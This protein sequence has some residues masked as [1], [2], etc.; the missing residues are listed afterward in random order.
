[1]VDVLHHNWEVKGSYLSFVMSEDERKAWREPLRTSLFSGVPPFINYV[2]SSGLHFGGHSL[3]C[4]PQ[5]WDEDEVRPDQPRCGSSVGRASFKRSG[6]GAT[7]LTDVTWVQIPAPWQ[8]EVGKLLA[9]LSGER[10]R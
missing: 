10:L 5:Y 1:M 8:K 6:F 9:A 7:L 2:P 3:E 4:G